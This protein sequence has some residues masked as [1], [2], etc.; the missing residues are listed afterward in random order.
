MTRARI[1]SF[2]VLVSLL[3][4]ECGT[5]DEAE[6]FTLEGT[7][8]LPARRIAQTYCGPCHSKGGDDPLPDRAYK[9]FKLDTYDQMKSRLFLM[10]N[11]L[12]I[13]GTHADMPPPTA[14]L[15]PTD[16]ERHLLLDWVERN[17]PNTPDG[18]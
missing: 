2:L 17:C 7:E 16:A 6:L 9:G 4:A 11:A 8:Y 1:L 18:R 13:H 12:T 14:K 10:L 3:S 5:D 15:Q